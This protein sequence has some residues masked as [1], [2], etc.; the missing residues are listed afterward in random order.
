MANINRWI[1]KVQ[2]SEIT[3]FDGFIETLENIRDL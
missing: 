2:K 1:A 3:C